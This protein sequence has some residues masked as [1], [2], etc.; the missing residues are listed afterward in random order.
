[1]MTLKKNFHY[2]QGKLAALTNKTISKI[3]DFLDYF[4][5]EYNYKSKFM[6]FACPIHEG[7]NKTALTLYTVGNTCVGNWKCQTHHCEKK[8]NRSFIG[9]TRGLLST[10][11]KREVSF[12]ETVNFLLDFNNCSFKQIEE[13][14]QNKQDPFDRICELFKNEE[15]RKGIERDR[16]LKYTRIPCPYHLKRGYSE[17]ILNKYDVGLCEDP[18]KSMY[19]R[20]V[21]PIYNDDRT[22]VM[23]YSGRS[24]FNKCMFCNGYHK[25][26]SACDENAHKWK[27]NFGFKKTLYLYNTWF[28]KPFIQKTYTAVLVESPGDTW[29]LVESGINNVVAL[30]GVELSAEQKHILGLLGC[31]NLILALN[32]DSAGLENIEII[33]NE[34]KNLYNVSALTLDTNDIGEMAVEDVKKTIVPQIR[35]IEQC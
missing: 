18:N 9:F 6:Q 17:Q 8:Y 32:K 11:K 27:N 31:T 16:W 2:S 12:K 26:G 28:A 3:E 15:S 35:R 33:K 34:C 14:E 22:E 20:S 13:V 23:G 1:M 19:M 30:F 25:F 4:D 5:I 24:I 29:R 10:R 7:D 21:V